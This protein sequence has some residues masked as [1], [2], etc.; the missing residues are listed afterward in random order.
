[1]IYISVAEL[2]ATLTGVEPYNIHALIGLE[3]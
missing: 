1:M 3:P 2:E